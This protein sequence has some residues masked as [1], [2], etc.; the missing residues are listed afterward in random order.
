MCP[1]TLLQL[2]DVRR[3]ARTLDGVALR[4]PVLRLGESVFLKAENFQR[5]GLRDNG[6]RSSQ[7]VLV[8]GGNPLVNAEIEVGDG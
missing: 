3:A 6:P 8:E 5:S 1:R 2:E 7:S 4:S